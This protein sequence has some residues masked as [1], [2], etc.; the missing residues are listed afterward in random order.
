M[1][2]QSNARRMEDAHEGEGDRLRVFVY[3]KG[4]RCKQEDR[5]VGVE[6]RRKRTVSRESSDISRERVRAAACERRARR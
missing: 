4:W 3:T 5:T 2:V 1:R 6:D